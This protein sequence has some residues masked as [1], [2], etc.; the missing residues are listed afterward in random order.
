MTFF[1]MAAAAALLTVMPLSAMAAEMPT[2]EQCE[3]WFVKADTNKDGA[4]GDQEESAKY[5]DMIS[6]GSESSSMAGSANVTL[7]K[8]DFVMGC[9]KGYFGM[10]AN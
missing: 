3:A 6:K 2:A 5:A 10:P 4:L 8:E 9:G 1:K 7:K